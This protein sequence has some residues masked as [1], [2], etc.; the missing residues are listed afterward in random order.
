MENL[1]VSQFTDFML[2][3][4][5]TDNPA[6][7]SVTT[8]LIDQIQ[9]G[10][11]AIPIHEIHNSN[12]NLPNEWIEELMQS[13]VVGQAGEFTPIVVDSGYI[14]LYRYWDYQQRLLNEINARIQL[15]NTLKDSTSLLETLDKLFPQQNDE[16]TDWQKFAAASALLKPFLIISGG[17]GTGKTTTVTKILKL[18]VQKH[19]QTQTYEPR[20][21]LAA[22][23][24]KAAMRMQ[25]SIRDAADEEL[26]TLLDDA[27]TIHRVLGYI[28]NQI[29]FRHNKQNPLSTDIVIID[30]ASMIDLALFTKLIEAI[31]E[32]AHLILLG[33]KDQLASVETGSVFN[34]LCATADNPFDTDT[35][36][37]SLNLEK[38]TAKQDIN[39]HIVVLQK[40]YRFTENSGIGHL[41]K[42]IKAGDVEKTLD[43]LVDRQFQDITQLSVSSLSTDFQQH[44]LHPWQDYFDAIKNKKSL[45]EIYLAFQQFRI[46][47]ALRIGQTGSETINQQ[48]EQHLQRQFLKGQSPWYEGRPI[49]ITQNNYQTGLFNGD[50]GIMLKDQQGELK[51]WFQTLKGQ[52]QSFPVSR[53]PSHET[54]WAMTIHKSQGSEFKH[55]LMILPD[56]DAPIINRELIY[57]GLTR[58][59]SSL[60]LIANSGVLNNG[61]KQKQ[62]QSTAIQSIIHTPP[63]NLVH[64]TS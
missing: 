55:I 22:P 57:T 32:T 44:C 40:S 39:E 61:L 53:L 46:L 43:L 64:P 52:W 36:K 56:V 35:I 14:Y 28:P 3:L 4:D 25:E 33:D 27:S 62:R 1:A 11:I 29:T 8:V 63:H 41:A 47:T 31:P 18:L 19:Y 59:K 16:G 34:D 9:Q 38:H 12:I 45:D 37:Q 15:H 26:N 21:V 6:V 20:I 30:E 42:A 2:K 51:T 7:A 60:K 23:T 58:A 54:A 24:G 50:I 10:R 5:T 13:R 48:V 17:P 49:M